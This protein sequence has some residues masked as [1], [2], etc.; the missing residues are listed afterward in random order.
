M[1]IFCEGY[2][3]KGYVFINGNCNLRSVRYIKIGLTYVI[4][5]K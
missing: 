3:Y 4:K 2:E 5:E 1:K